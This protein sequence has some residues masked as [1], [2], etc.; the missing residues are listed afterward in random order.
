MS[1]KIKTIM[2]NCIQK[3]VLKQKNEWPIASIPVFYQPERPQQEA[4]KGKN[5]TNNLP[6]II[7]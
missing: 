6:C 4:L 7:E 3:A 1:K 5:T 2:G